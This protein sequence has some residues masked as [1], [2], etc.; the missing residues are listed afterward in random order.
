MCLLT[1]K[2]LIKHSCFFGQTIIQADFATV[3]MTFKGFGRGK[4][5]KNQISENFRLTVNQT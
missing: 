4:I 2:K 5:F 3:S 1:S